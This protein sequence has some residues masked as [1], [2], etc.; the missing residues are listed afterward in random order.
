MCGRYGCSR[1]ITGTPTF[2]LNGVYISADS[3]W[4]LSD[5]QSV[6]DPIINASTTR[7]ARRPSHPTNAE[8]VAAIS[9]VLN[10][11][12]HRYTANETCASNLTVCD[13]APKK[14]ECCTKGENC[15]PNV[16]CRCVT[17]SC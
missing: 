10:K 3:S 8:P 9:A 11:A 16:G 2:L 12:V 5:W 7:A 6:I 17:A 4:A 14:F 1:G 13:Y 15:I